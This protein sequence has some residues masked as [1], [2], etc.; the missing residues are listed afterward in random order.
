MRARARDTDVADDIFHASPFSRIFGRRVT[1]REARTFP[2]TS[3]PVTCVTWHTLSH[4][5]EDEKYGRLS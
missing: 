3:G 4:R 1:T 5:G 2:P